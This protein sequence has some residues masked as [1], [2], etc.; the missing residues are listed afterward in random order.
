M[1]KAKFDNS[2]NKKFAKEILKY[3]RG[4]YTREKLKEELT[5]MVN[6]TDKTDAQSMDTGR[7]IEV[8]FVFDTNLDNNTRLVWIAI[9]APDPR[10][11]ESVTA[12]INRYHD[13]L[14]PTDQDAV[15]EE[16]GKS[17]L[18]GCGR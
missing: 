16:L 7:K 12:F 2:D 1:A 4:T 5:K 15:E 9:P 14:S 6:K 10:T 13:N 11:T 3:W 18:F 17:C 8:D